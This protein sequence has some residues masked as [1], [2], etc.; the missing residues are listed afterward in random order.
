MNTKLISII[1]ILAIIFSACSTGSKEYYVS[2]TGDDAN[3]GTKASPFKTIEHALEQVKG[4]GTIW[5]T[6]GTYNPQFTLFLDKLNSGTKDNP[7]VL[8]GVEGDKVVMTRGKQMDSKRFKKVTS[9]EE[10]D[11]L[12]EVAQGKVFVADLTG[13]GLED[14]FQVRPDELKTEFY[15][16][17][18]WNGF[19]LQQAQ[20]PNRGYD[21]ISETL[22]QGPTTR[23]LKKNEEPAA[24]SIDEPT[25][26]VFKVRGVLDYKKLKAEFDRTK[27]IGVFGYHSNDWFYQKENLG[28]VNAVDENLKLLRFTRYGVG[29]PKLPLPRRVKLINVLCELDEPGEWYYDHVDKKFYIWPVEPLSNE[30]PLT[31]VGGDPFIDAQGSEHITLRNIIFENFGKY[32]VKF[33]RCNNIL[34]GG[35]TFRSG[36]DLGLLLTDGTDNTITG[37]DF[38]DLDRAFLLMGVYPSESFKY[39][40]QYGPGEPN[41]EYNKGKFGPNRRN[42]INENNVASNNHIHHCRLKGYGLASVG[43]VGAKFENNLIHNLNGGIMY[44]YNDFLAQYN[45][46][47]DVGYEMGDWNAMYC[48]ADLSFY[49][50]MMKFNFVHHIMETPKGHPESAW[51]ADDNAS[52]LLTYGNIYYKCGRSCSQGS[53]PA[54]SIENSISLETPYYWWT[55]QKPY[56]QI[57]KK[58]FFESKKQEHLD[59]QKAIKEGTLMKFDKWNLLG[60]AE[61][62]FGKEGWKYNKAWL[63]RYPYLPTIFN[64]LTDEDQ[65]P[66]CQTVDT[67][68]YNYSDNP[69]AKSFH[70]HGRNKLEPLEDMRN[71]LP[72]TAHLD[73]PVE[74]DAEAMFVNVN[75]LDFRMKE[76]FQP[77]DGFEEIPFEK[78]GLY[79]DEYRKTMPDKKEYRKAVKKKYE[80]ISSHK[81][82]FDYDKLNE[83]YPTP[84]YLR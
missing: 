71:F 73:A 80:G 63:E 53:G 21:Y 70:I 44:G 11:R 54:H 3:N 29:N 20:W 26:A 33:E 40:S 69:G 28:A 83:R 57:S 13:T 61:M 36:I 9:V 47:Y 39:E 16:M 7:V 50:N 22:D 30:K 59:A 79:I 12:K 84:P 68:R 81:S 72:G 2:P 42:L 74:I 1:A 43:G 35:C 77:I 8:R 5:L 67:I 27:D 65:N 62:V 14:M 32:G 37:C 64:S 41:F 4:G 34:V 66:W 15:T 23:W 17:I 51:R 52:G 78:I 58:E 48:G 31:I 6:E 10:L 18:N 46:F 60:K 55:V 76:G 24:Y 82:Q 25:G 45:E 38:Y 19:V 56:H 49:N 75:E